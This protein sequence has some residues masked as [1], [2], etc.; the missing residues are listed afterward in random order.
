MP[1]ARSSESRSRQSRPC[2]RF[3]KNART[4]QM[5]SGAIIMETRRWE[6]K[7]SDGTTGYQWLD[8]AKRDL[9]LQ[10]PQEIHMVDELVS[11]KLIHCIP[12][13]RMPKGPARS[14]AVRVQTFQT[15]VN[16]G[17]PR[18][19][20]SATSNPP[21]AK[22]RRSHPSISVTSLQLLPV[23]GTALVSAISHL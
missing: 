15:N 12:V 21:R 18:R 8:M 13:P 20:P 3:S 22:L 10:D 6:T 23:H 1:T 2:G 7:R 5:T 16:A 14:E 11:E 17:P 9:N 4:K 19:V